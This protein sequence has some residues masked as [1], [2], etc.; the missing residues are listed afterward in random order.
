[1]FLVLCPSLLSITF[2]LWGTKRDSKAKRGGGDMVVG[3]VDVSMGGSD[4]HGA[5]LDVKAMVDGVLG[6]MG[7]EKKR[8][9]DMSVSDFMQL[10]GGMNE[11]GIHFS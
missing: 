1:M 7:F 8:A 2:F 11:V 4:A 6:K 9:R 3:G 5:T 10:L